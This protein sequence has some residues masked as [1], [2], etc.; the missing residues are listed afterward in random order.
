MGAHSA[1][2]TNADVDRN[3]LYGLDILSDGANLFDLAFGISSQLPRLGGQ[4]FVRDRLWIMQLAQPI[5]DLGPVGKSLEAVGR[6]IALR[7][8]AD[9]HARYQ[10]RYVGTT[11]FQGNGRQISHFPGVIRTVHDW[12][13]GRMVESD[14]PA[15]P[16]Q[17]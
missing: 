8:K 17:R 12:L 7:I 13:N 1:T 14:A 3:V 4:S 2:T 10:A 9:C 6:R 5:R 15:R 11:W 16:S